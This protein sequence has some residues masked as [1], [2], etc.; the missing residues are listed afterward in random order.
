MQF[1]EDWLN[2][3]ESTVLSIKTDSSTFASEVVSKQIKAPHAVLTRQSLGRNQSVVTLDIVKQSLRS[4]PIDK[5]HT[6]TFYFKLSRLIADSMQG[7]NLRM[8]QNALQQTG[9]LYGESD[10]SIDFFTNLIIVVINHYQ[11]NVR[12]YI[13]IDVSNKTYQHFLAFLFYIGCKVIVISDTHF[14]LPGITIR[15]EEIMK[16]KD[17]LLSA[18]S[19]Q[20]NPKQAAPAL[21]N[22]PVTPKSP[23]IQKPP[24]QIKFVKA[25]S[26]D[27]AAKTFFTSNE[28]EVVADGESVVIPVFFS[29][30]IGL[31]VDY[32]ADHFIWLNT[33]KKIKD[34]LL[35]NK[36]FMPID[37][38]FSSYLQYEQHAERIV[39]ACAASTNRFKMVLNHFKYKRAISDFEADTIL[40][41]FV[42]F[43]AFNASASKPLDLAKA[44]A[45]VLTLFDSCNVCLAA[46]KLILYYGS[47][48]P[49]DIACA[50]LLNHFGYSVI[51]I[52]TDLD[53]DDMNNELLRSMKNITTRFGIASRKDIAFPTEEIILRSTSTM[54]PMLEQ[55][56]LPF[57]IGN[58]KV[59]NLSLR[60]TY[61]ELSHLVFTEAWMR[62]N[63]RNN[64]KEVHIPNLF[65]KLNGVPDDESGY[66][67]LVSELKSEGNDCENSQTYFLHTQPDSNQSG[68]HFRRHDVRSSL[69]HALNQDGG[70]NANALQRSLLAKDFNFINR[71]AQQVLFMKINELLIGKDLFVQPLN[72]QDK[73]LALNA[74]FTLWRPTIFELLHNFDFCTVIPKLVVF[75]GVK[76][77]RDSDFRVA[78]ILMLANLLGFDVL[79]FTPTGFAGIENFLHTNQ[80]TV[81]TLGSFVQSY[82]LQTNHDVT[83]SNVTQSGGLIQGL[84]NLISSKI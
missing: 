71:N 1:V 60:A 34:D 13:A 58:H 81:H 75:S 76:D 82:S 4:I 68:I 23:E 44:M 78:V 20:L 9:V 77:A 31:A 62:P 6:I 45:K 41:W 25:R 80:L 65:V 7:A 74:I 54:S 28:F 66:E 35:A 53:K 84:K 16:S 14:N 56:S 63:Y 17:K 50:W 27:T 46:K 72:Q 59:T 55:Y 38:G 49:E 61:E 51:Q 69:Q 19:V 24:I 26:I 39:S 10:N 8:I 5:Y 83:Q 15:R 52:S 70:L 2:S 40:E 64:D 43:Q 21:N 36:N 67:V 29:R 79:V 57:T 37:L 30:S 33:W 3:K 11:L 22:S 18:P 12:I 47:M 48:S 42:T 73:L 32:E